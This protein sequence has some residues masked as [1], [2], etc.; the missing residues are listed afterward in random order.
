MTNDDFNND[1][2][3]NVGEKWPQYWKSSPPSS[4]KCQNSANCDFE[5]AWEK[6]WKWSN[7]TCADLNILKA[8]QNQKKWKM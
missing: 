2:Y 4:K 8:V 5:K 6:E 7:Y 1:I 3:E